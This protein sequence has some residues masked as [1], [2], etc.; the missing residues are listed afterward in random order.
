[1]HVHAPTYR[2][3]ALG[4]IATRPD[5]RG[6]GLAGVVTAGLCKSLLEA[7]DD[8]GL[9]VKAD[10]APAIRCYRRLGFEVIGS[11][12]EFMAEPA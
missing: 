8:I 4:G 2:V 10:N 1:V 5:A 12:E 7:A 11:Y 9:N 3:A 6:K